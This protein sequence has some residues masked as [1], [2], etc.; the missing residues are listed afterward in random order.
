[1]NQHQSREPYLSNNQPNE[2]GAIMVTKCRDEEECM[3][4]R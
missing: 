2:L 4:Q 1:M 3:F